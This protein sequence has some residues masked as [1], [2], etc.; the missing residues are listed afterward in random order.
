MYSGE[1]NWHAEAFDHETAPSSVS[2]SS[3]RQLSLEIFG[4]G[5]L[6]PSLPV[7]P[8]VERRFSHGIFRAVSPPLHGEVKTSK[9]SWSW[10]WIEWPLVFRH[11]PH[12]AHRSERY[13]MFLFGVVIYLSINLFICFLLRA[14]VLLS[15]LAVIGGWMSRI[16]FWGR[17]TLGWNHIFDRGIASLESVIDSEVLE[18]QPFSPM[19]LNLYAVA[20]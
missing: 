3:F 11:C 12:W 2:G 6:Y 14:M 10:S 8:A 20:T 13:V 9:V 1:E 16:P 15:L 5:T 18:A 4:V 17:L 7:G 19:R